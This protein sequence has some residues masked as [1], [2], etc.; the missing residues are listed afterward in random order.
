MYKRQSL[1]LTHI[2]RASVDG[3]AIGKNTLLI[4]SPKLDVRNVNIKDSNPIKIVFWG[5]DPNIDP[6]ILKH[7]DIFFIT[8]FTHP[9]ENVIP[10]LNDNY[11]L[12][13]LFKNLNIN[14]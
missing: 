5:A 4:D 3:I 9:A 1:A 11:D 12:N 14:S 2:L 7:S 10:I 6:H 8:S 13:K